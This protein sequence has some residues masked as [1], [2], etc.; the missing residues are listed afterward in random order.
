MFDSLNSQMKA[1]GLEPSRKDRWVLWFTV[2]AATALVFAGLYFGLA[3]LQ[4]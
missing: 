1:S 2:A 3:S 4:G